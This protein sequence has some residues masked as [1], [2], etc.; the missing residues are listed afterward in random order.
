MLHIADGDPVLV[1]T[2]L[3]SEG[4]HGKRAAHDC[5]SQNLLLKIQ[6]RDA[7]V[8]AMTR[9]HADKDRSL[10]NAP[11][12][13]EC[14]E[15]KGPLPAGAVTCPECGAIQPRGV[16]GRVAGIRRAL[17]SKLKELGSGIQCGRGEDGPGPTDKQ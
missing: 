10:R 15:C 7:A 3:K 11:P 5:L 1:V 13:A 12:S 8:N 2:P 6:R 14:S 17:E 9:Y 4:P 16:Q